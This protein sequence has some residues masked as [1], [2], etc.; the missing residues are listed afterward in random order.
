MQVVF[1][2]VAVTPENLQSEIGDLFVGLTGIEFQDG[3]VP[4]RCLAP[5]ETS[6]VALDEHLRYLDQHLHIG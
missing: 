1:H 3:G 4:G 2:R 5:I 6:R